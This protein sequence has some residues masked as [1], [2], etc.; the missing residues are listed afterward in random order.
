MLKYF[1]YSVT[2]AEF[3][4]EIA[5]CVNVSNCP[6]K[7]EKCSE[8]WLSQDIGFD[9]NYKS[10]SDLIKKNPGI[11]LFGFMGGDNDPIERVNLSKFIK[12]N[13]GIRTG[14]YSGANSI[15]LDGIETFDYYKFGSWIYPFDKNGDLICYKQCGPICYVGTNQ[16]MFKIKDGKMEDITYR[17]QKDKI[18]NLKNFVKE[19]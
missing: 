9:L 15:Y 3:P 18:S 14:V 7:C 2:F 6:N 5:L 13:F 17:F 8:S 1:D 12:N 11:T 4:D 16:K 19:D 10:V